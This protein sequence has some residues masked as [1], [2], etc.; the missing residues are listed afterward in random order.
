MAAISEFAYYTSNGENDCF[1]LSLCNLLLQM[2]DRET[3][4]RVNRTYYRHRYTEK[5]KG[6]N[7]HIT[8]LLVRELTKGKY[9]ATLHIFIPPTNATQFHDFMAQQSD[10]DCAENGMYY[11][12]RKEIKSDRIIEHPYL[13]DRWRLPSPSIITVPIEKGAYHAMVYSNPVPGKHMFIIDN[14]HPRIID[15]RRLLVWACLNVKR[16]K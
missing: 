3:A 11:E 1:K 14:G 6:V 9:D 7:T 2:D 5:D 8:T 10:R 15:K 16:M 13:N 4:G 12:I